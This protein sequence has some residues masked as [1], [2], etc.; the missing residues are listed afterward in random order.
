MKVRIPIFTQCGCLDFGG[1]N[2]CRG[3][4]VPTGEY[5]TLTVSFLTWVS[6][7][8]WPHDSGLPYLIDD[9][10]YVQLGK[11]IWRKPEAEVVVLQREHDR[12]KLDQYLQAP[13]EP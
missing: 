9:W 8:L 10:G 13:R 3:E 7:M 2:Q 5:E 1:C 4:P 12:A 6:A 11:V